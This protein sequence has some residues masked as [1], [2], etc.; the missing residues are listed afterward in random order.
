M[1]KLVV[2]ESPAK[3][4]TI[5]KYLGAGYEVKSS[6]GHIVDLPKSQ[7]GIDVEHNYTP[8]YEVTKKQV[9]AEL[10]KAL[11]DKDGLVLAVDPDREGEAIGWHIARQLGYLDKDGQ[12]VK[13]GKDLQRIVFTEITKQAIQAAVEKPRELDF[14]LID[15]QQ[16][17]RVLDRLVGYKLSPLLWKK[18]QYGLSAGRV[19]SVALKLVV[20]R[21]REREAFKPEEYWSVVAYL[22]EQK[23]GKPKIGI[24]L[25]PGKD[26]TVEKP[27]IP[28]TLPAFKLVKYK[29]KKAE[30]ANQVQIDKIAKDLA[31]EHSWQVSDTTTKTQEKHPRSPFTTSLLQQAASGRLGF[32]ATRTMKVAQQLYEAGHI[33]YM[34]TDSL[35]MSDQA[36]KA[37]EAHVKKKY[38]A[39]Y[40][41]AKARQY[42]NKSKV[43]QEAH[44]A[45]RPTQVDKDAKALG[46]E[47]EQAALYDLIR[48]RA[49]A[50][51]MASAKISVNKVSVD[52]NNTYVFQANG[53]NII[54][55]GYLRVYN[56]RL[57][58]TDLPP[59][60]QGQELFPT[61]ID[62]DQHFTE[63]PARYSEAALVKKLEELGIGR[64]STYAPTIQTIISRKY[65]VK[66]NKYLI[67]TDIGKVVTDLLSKY[68]ADIVDAGFTAVMEN[69]LDQVA[70]GEVAWEKI[71]DDFYKPFEKKVIEKDKAIDRAEFTVLGKSTEK[72]PECGKPMIIKLGRFG[73]FLSC[74]DFPTCKGMLG[75]DAAGNVQ[76]KL[77]EK[78]TE[79]FLAK[80]LPAP[81]TEDG[82]SY[83]LKRG[84]FGEFWAHPDY[85]KVKDAKPIELRPEIVEQLYGKAPTGE[86]G[87]VYTL[88]SGKFGLFWAHP[89]YPKVK[90]V[91]K[92]KLIEEQ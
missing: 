92:A 53:Q 16:A 17:R 37:I 75:L 42:A 72:C 21:E 4:K 85:P 87:A 51:L 58:E 91:I 88:R 23:H 31:G 13:K 26:E 47:A 78:P 62:L 86:K 19:Q 50:S 14:N 71:I 63:P 89:D 10:K 25:K 55:P 33:T 39:E 29:G 76:A 61:Q 11:K 6:K 15:A 65:V 30:L 44:E 48:T 8:T 56:E 66:E 41:P 7:L 82:R 52:V 80:Y 81:K 34:R 59:Y 60:K 2:V 73:K 40:L 64:P 27:E 9:L 68:F 46:L 18:I 43:T 77:D 67:P 70:N 36:V 57:L 5:Q 3:A 45:I 22:S 83:L 32:G 12:K 20:D 74:S 54:F 28:T 90:K 84:R 1:N 79:E 69:Q 49:V 24:N 35:H 38:G